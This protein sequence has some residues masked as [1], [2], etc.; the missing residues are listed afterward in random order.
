MRKELYI[1]ILL[2][3]LTLCVKYVGQ[4]PEFASGALLGLSI[5]LEIIGILPQERYMKLKNFK[6]RSLERWVR[7]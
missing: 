2:F 6:K 4:I 5:C 3:F 7:K 1:G